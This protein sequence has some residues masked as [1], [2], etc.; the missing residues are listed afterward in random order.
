MAELLSKDSFWRR[1][2]TAVFWA[3]YLPTCA[4]VLDET[5]PKALRRE[6]IRRLVKRKGLFRE[7]NVMIHMWVYLHIH[8]YH[9]A[10]ECGSSS[11]EQPPCLPGVGQFSK[12][13][14]E[15]G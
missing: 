7:V 14:G 12:V 6:S 15:G 2:E 10:H 8:N 1:V 4:R 9:L 3:G 11:L 5:C 13:Q